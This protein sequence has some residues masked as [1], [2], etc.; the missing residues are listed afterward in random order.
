MPGPALSLPAGRRATLTMQVSVIA[1]Y[2]Q[3]IYLLPSSLPAGV[4][5]DIPS[6]IVGS[7]V[8]TINV[9]AAGSSKVQTFPITIYAA[10]SGQNQSASF[11]LS[12]LAQTA[13]LEQSGIARHWIGAW[14]ASAVVPSTEGGAYYLTNVTV[15]QIAHLSIGSVSGLRIR[16]SNALGRSAVT[17]GEVHVAQWAGSCENVT[18]AILPATDRIVT[19]GGSR[20]V[21]LAAGADILSDRV[22]L[23]VPAGTD[24]AISLYIPRTSNVPATIH[25]F[26][27]QTAY[28]S[29]GNSTGSVI[30]PN[31]ITDT[32]R[33]YLTGID[34]ETA[35][36]ATLV[37]LGDSI[38]DG[39]LSSLNR[40]LRWPDELARRL[41]ETF[42]DGVGVVNEGIAG[43][44][45]L[46]NCM[47][48]SALDRLERDVLSVAGAKY[49]IIQEGGSDIG[50]APDLRAAQLIDAYRSLI[51]LAHAHG[52]LVFGAT[53][54]PF[55]GSNSFTTM[56]EQL[57]QEVNAFIRTGG[58]F[59][60]VI[61]FDKAI[62]NPANPAY[63]L[64]QYNG[65]NVRPN[66]AG[67]QAMAAAIDLT[68]LNP[69]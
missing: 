61:D 14:G 21:I 34:V 15:R 47:G 54:T 41:N 52:I 48:P 2:R 45:V 68:P 18:S 9:I 65:D 50:N 27:N 3:P 46:M 24:V 31:A 20:T 44:C 25:M 37:A 7:Q 58:A 11:S 38:T 5:I 49:L 29:L 63:L 64:P 4:S 69:R 62:A 10:S 56:H 13:A 39:M 30:V 6:P 66:D 42:G 33:P 16:L 43:N 53:I 57:R 67:Y 23:K 35:G 59:D 55:G 26:G 22:S 19:F 51:A 40:N 17:F 28:F 32:V 8:V 12:I 60:G 1:G 36:A